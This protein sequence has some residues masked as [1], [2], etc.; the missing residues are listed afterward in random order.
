MDGRIEWPG[1]AGLTFTVQRSTTLGGWR[2][3]ATVD[4][5][6]PVTGFTDP[7]PPAG[8]AFYRIRFTP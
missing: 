2:E 5:V 7:D 1:A 3:I 6:A 4:G 8:R